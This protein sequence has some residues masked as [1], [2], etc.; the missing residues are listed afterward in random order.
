LKEDHRTGDVVMSSSPPA[1][2]EIDIEMKDG[3]DTTPR[4]RKHAMAS[5]DPESEDEGVDP[6]SE[7][8]EPFKMSLISFQKKKKHL[9]LV[10]DTDEDSDNEKADKRDRQRVSRFCCDSLIII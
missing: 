7:D 8:E 10:E 9:W 3:S 1:M 6:E 4:P 2:N 5:I